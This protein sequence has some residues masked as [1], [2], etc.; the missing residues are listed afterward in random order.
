[1]NIAQ[2]IP[3]ADTW[4]MHGDIGTGW[5]IVMMVAMVLFWGAI[6]LGVVWLIRRG[7]EG[8]PGRRPHTAI[9]VLDHRFAQGEISA[10]EYR[11]RRAVLANGT[12]EPN[13]HHNDEPLTAPPAGEGRRS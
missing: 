10:E 3:L 12:A 7:F 2:T 6:I 1:M 8:G 13:G 11:A 5:W 4:G 9:E